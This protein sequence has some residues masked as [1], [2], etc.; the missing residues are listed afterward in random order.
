LASLLRTASIIACALV[1][2]GF[3][4]FASDQAGAGSREQV[5]KIKNAVAQPSPSLGDELAREHEHGK[6]RE[7]ID[8]AN[9]VLLAPF[10]GLASSQSNPWVQ[11]LIPTV[12]GLLLYGLGL[13]MLANFLPKPDNKSTDWRDAGAAG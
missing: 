10:S 13:V 2:L 8:D 1:A 3:V 9:D 12:L 7:A 5:E 6:P 11:R 4:M